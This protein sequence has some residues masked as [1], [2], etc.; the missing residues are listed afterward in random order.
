[1]TPPRTDRD[2]TAPAWVPAAQ[3]L[4]P[5]STVAEARAHLRVTGESVAPVL[6][7]GRPVGLV[8]AGALHDAERCGCCDAPVSAVM[9]YLAVPVPR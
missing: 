2:P 7:H 4:T 5:A 3:P 6:R 1:M 8:S 9:D